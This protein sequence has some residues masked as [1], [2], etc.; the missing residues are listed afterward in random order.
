VIGQ[1]WAASE[2]G[3][4]EVEHHLASTIAVLMTSKETAFTRTPR[5]SYSIACERAP[6]ALHSAYTAWMSSTRIL[7]KLLTR[8]GSRG[9]SR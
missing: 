5:G 1:K 8:S 4:V 7:R 2:A 3:D 9:V 6:R